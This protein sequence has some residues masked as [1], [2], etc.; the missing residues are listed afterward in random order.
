MYPAN[1]I[2]LLFSGITLF[3]PAQAAANRPTLEE[4]LDIPFEELVNIEVSSVGFFATP[5]SK[6]PGYSYI[7]TAEEIEKSPERSLSDIIEMKVPGMTTGGHE[8]HG[9]II[10]TRGIFID[11]NAKTMVML[12]EQPINQRSHFGYTAGLLSPLL[13][14][15]RQ[16]EVILGPGAILHGSGALNGFINLL[17]KNGKDN[18]GVFF[19]SEYGFAEELWKVESG[20]GTSYGEEKNIYLYGGLYGAEGYEPEKMYGYSKTFDIHAKGFDEGNS[21]FSLYWN[22]DRFNLNTFYYENNPYKNSSAEIDHFHQTTLG[23][24]PKYVF[25][26]PHTDTFEV[27]GSL[28][29]F[30]HSSP[31]NLPP[32][33]LIEDR[34]GSENHWELKN[35]YR[36]ARWKD[37]LLA[38]GF[39]Y[40]EKYF[41]Q[42]D[43]F[44]SDD[45]QTWLGTVD[46][47]WREASLFA[48]DVVALND[49]WTASLGLRYDK[50]DLGTME[51]DTWIG[52][53]SANEI[54]GNFSPR[55]ATAYELDAKTT[56]KA[57]YQHG[58]RTPD[59][60]YYMQ[61]LT[62]KDIAESL[63]LRF[64]SLEIETMDS[65][66]LNLQKELPEHKLRVDC[67]LFYNIFK[68]RLS[69]KFYDETG[70]FTPAELDDLKRNLGLPLIKEVRLGSFLN[71]EEKIK[72]YGGEINASFRPLSH[73]EVRLSYG[74]AQLED[75]DVMQ[76]PE[77]QIKVNTLSSFWN[78][79]INF[80]LSYLYNS[81]YAESYLP[82]AHSIY[83]DD[84]HLVDA[85]LT[86]NFNPGTSLR[87]SVNNLFATDVP[88][89]IFTPDRLD[90]GGLGYDERRVYLAFRF[91]L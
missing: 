47:E 69:W 79:R 75:A 67:N 59:A 81:S 11:N 42:K 85:A 83:R 44:F 2:A 23:I 36:T 49:R 64:P 35:V 48:E 78:D 66:E 53:K 87:L 30:D 29:W 90:M 24:R 34:G 39:S 33:D 4:L 10:G 18:P 63:A 19:D 20:Y 41:F 38:A 60:F 58:F 57:S 73:T 51:S 6:A 5:A 50:I 74:Y 65:F 27:L 9:P 22:H 12:D 70:L 3:I 76:Y 77:H 25:E 1:R 72:A 86:Y 68:D 32:T 21:R 40:G 91:S 61:Y 16:A 13:G 46:T 45:T 14:D 26:L 89:M 17:P 43:Q 37:H 56:V 55:I 15:I 88:P 82:R 52:E 28:L 71:D 84:R 62:F 8:R 31:R 54:D 7:I 80:S